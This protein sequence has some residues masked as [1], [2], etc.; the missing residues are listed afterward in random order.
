MHFRAFIVL[1]LASLLAACSASPHRHW[2]P[3]EV[4]RVPDT[5]APYNLL[6]RYDADGDGRITRRELEAGLRQDFRKADTN[7]DGR[8]DV[9]EVR[10]ENQRR[11]HLDQSDAIPLIDWDHDGYVDFEEFAAPIRSLFE[12]YDVDDDGVVTL[13]E[14][15]IRIEHKPPAKPSADGGASGSH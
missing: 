3:N 13:D 4:S 6:L 10:A 14:M 9:D 12:Q 2:S 1:A 7:H 15:H 8:L 11:I 5:H